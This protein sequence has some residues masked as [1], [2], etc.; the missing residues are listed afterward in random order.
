MCDVESYIYLPMLEELGYMPKHR[1]SYGPEIRGYAKQ[2]AEHFG[3]YDLALF[4]TAVNGL[5][6]QEDADM[7]GQH[8]P[9]R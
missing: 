2:L 6:W 8:R 1:Y 5:T 4:H 9:R 3:L 7:A